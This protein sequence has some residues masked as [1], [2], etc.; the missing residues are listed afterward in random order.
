[1]ILLDTDVMVDA[2]RKYPPAVAWLTSLGNASIG[3][4]G[5]VALELLQGCANRD[6]QSQVETRLRPYRIYWP[7]QA[8]CGR[9]YKDYV[10]NHLSHGL[11]ILDALIAETAVGQ[12]AI[13]ATFNTKHYRVITALQVMEPY[14]RGS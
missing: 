5:L 14:E 7:Q 8:D 12:G 11:G 9:A 1:M 2:L 13:L 10:H 3:V 4:P 6:E